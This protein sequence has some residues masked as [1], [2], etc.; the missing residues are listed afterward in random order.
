[1]RGFDSEHVSFL[2]ALH[3]FLVKYVV[4]GGHAAIYHGVNRNTGD[5]VI[6]IEPTVENGHRLINVFNFLKLDVPPINDAEWTT[7]LVLSFGF[8]PDAIDILNYSPGISFDE[9]YKNSINVNQE[10]VEI[11]IIDIRD[12]IKN[13]EALNRTGEKAHLDRY[14][15]EVLK[16]IIEKRR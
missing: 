16:R 15:I 12:L 2:K 9:V 13:K 8:E 6:L 4:I 10:G 5:L 11:P 3:K 1:M 14:D 7:Q